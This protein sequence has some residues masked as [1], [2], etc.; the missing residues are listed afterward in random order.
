MVGLSYLNNYKNNYQL[1][2]SREHTVEI[3]GNG[4]AAGS[5]DSSVTILMAEDNLVN[6]KLSQ[7]LFKR[8]DIQVDMVSNGEQA[9][10]AVEN[11]SY[12]LV[13][14]DI[15]MPIMDGMEAT[16]EIKKQHGDKSPTIIA[17]TANAMDGDRERFLE[18]GMDDYIAKPISLDALKNF[19]AKYVSSSNI[20]E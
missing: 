9:V 7:L 2:Y 1:Q 17:L 18:A 10:E 6:Q 15:Q 12:E 8:L 4:D 11:G 3:T 14:M 19:V 16:A 5:T 20:G 13:F